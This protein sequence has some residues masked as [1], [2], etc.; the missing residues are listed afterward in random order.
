MSYEILKTLH[1][2]TYE[3]RAKR[4]L[5]SLFW[6]IIRGKI[7]S[8]SAWQIIGE[9]AFN[10]FLGGRVEAARE[11]RTRSGFPSRDDLAVIEA[12][13]EKFTED[14]NR[15]LWDYKF[16]GETLPRCYWRLDILGQVLVWE[17]Y[18]RGKLSLFRIVNIR[19]QRLAQQYGE[20][21]EYVCWFTALDER[22]CP[23]CLS[24]HGSCWPIWATFP[25]PPIHPGCR[26]E[27]IA[28][29]HVETA[30]REVAAVAVG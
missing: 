13:T 2:R 9:M 7:P 5:R 29:L 4:D 26:C 23:E 24:L 27:L 8:E 22:V 11:I 20:R 10:A 30:G 17:L 18:N 1:P 25:I 12:R 21:V 6:G 3:P 14:F 19:L 16:G 15:I 28:E